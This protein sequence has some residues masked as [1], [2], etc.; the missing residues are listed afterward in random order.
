MAATIICSY[1]WP[2]A[3]GRYNYLTG[4]NCPLWNETS[5][6]TRET[7]LNDLWSQISKTSID[8]FFRQESES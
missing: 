3:F 8:S 2:T 5:L 7:Q 1:S 6:N 4:V